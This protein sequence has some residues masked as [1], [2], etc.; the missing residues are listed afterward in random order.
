MCEIYLYSRLYCVIDVQY[1]LATFLIFSASWLCLLY[2][3]QYNHKRVPKYFFGDWLHLLN[4]N[5]RFGSDHHNNKFGNFWV[6]KVWQLYFSLIDAWHKKLLTI[7]ELGTNQMLQNHVSWYR[8]HYSQMQWQWSSRIPTLTTSQHNSKPSERVNYQPVSHN[9]ANFDLL[10]YETIFW[11]FLHIDCLFPL[12]STEGAATLIE[13]THF[14][15]YL[16]WIK[17]R[18]S[19]H[20]LYITWF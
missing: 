5:W 2:H 8:L 10:K 6:C 17:R 12:F 14:Y 19:Y 3:L 18:H 7:L 20:P 11:L 15:S 1:S 4:C 16:K 13:T 9:K